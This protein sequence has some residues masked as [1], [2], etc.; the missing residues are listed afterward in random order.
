LP[1]INATD[2]AYILKFIYEGEIKINKQ[3]LSTFVSAAK[4]LHIR[5]MDS[6]YHDPVSD[7]ST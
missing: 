3:A 6:D 1:H 7:T 4:L 5:G 2:I